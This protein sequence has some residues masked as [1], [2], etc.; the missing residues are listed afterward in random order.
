MTPALGPD[1]TVRT[2]ARAASSIEMVP[3]L[4][5]LM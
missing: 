5:W 3:P 1:S 4:D 2:G